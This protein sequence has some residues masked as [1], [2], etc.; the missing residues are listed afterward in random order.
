MAQGTSILI[1][2]CGALA[3]E[4]I[5]VIRANNWKQVTVQCLP[6]ELHNTPQ[7]IP[8]AVSAKIQ[9]AREQFERI[10]VA[11]GDCGTGGQLD[12]VLAQQ[13]IERISGAHCYEFFAGA[14]VFAALAEAEPGSFYLTDFLAQHFDRLV[15]RGLGLDR[16]PELAACYFGNYNRLVY[17]AQRRDPSL[18]AKARE[19]AARLELEFAYQFT[20]YGD[21]Q[22]VLTHKV[23][24]WQS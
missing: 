21:L 20:G 10:F 3:R 13:G 19:A 4:I 17:L 12:A 22:R 6:A 23:Q 15:Y 18:L 24:A 7:Q 1:I 14:S 16:F 2:A 8:Q 9:A 5:A 11:Y